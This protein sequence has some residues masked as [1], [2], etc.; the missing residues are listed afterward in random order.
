[1][2]E[3]RRS[4]KPTPFSTPGSHFHLWPYLVTLVYLSFGSHDQF[5]KH[6]PIYWRERGDASFCLNANRR[7][8]SRLLAIM[9]GQIL[10]VYPILCPLAALLP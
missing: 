1:M 6:E 5:V 10:Q 3:I 7:A 8:R 4:P 9:L 2:T